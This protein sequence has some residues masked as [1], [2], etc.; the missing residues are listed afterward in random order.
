MY[1]DSVLF[2]GNA[3]VQ[4]AVTDSLPDCAD[5][6]AVVL[7]A[8]FSG[9]DGLAPVL[10]P[11]NQNWVFILLAGLF[12]LFV[13]AVRMT[14]GFFS[15]DIKTLFRV[16]E[17]SS[18]FSNSTANDSRFYILFIIFSFCVI[19]LYAYFILYDPAP[20][21]PFVFKKFLYFLL[22]TV[23]FFLFKFLSISLLGY[24]F[25]DPK[26]MVV[27]KKNFMY[28]VVLTGIVLFGLLVMNIYAIPS[29]VKIVEIVLLGVLISLCIFVVFKLF[30]IF[31]SKLLDSFYILLYL[32]TLEILPV[33]ALFR[34]YQ[35]IL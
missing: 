13:F 24:V 27:A 34:V 8:F 33:V 22:A 35:L 1:S 31:L 4:P 5:S 16:K 26:V 6:L 20:D 28:L 32:C 3:V 30:Q 23:S 21:N 18:I 25:F 17:R 15:E 14:P 29:V 10:Y 12:L 2:L 7:P 11:Q 9:Y 19:S